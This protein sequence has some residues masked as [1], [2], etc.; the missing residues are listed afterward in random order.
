[1]LYLSHYVQSTEYK[2]KKNTIQY[3]STNVNSG[4]KKK[5]EI[6][7]NKQQKMTEKYE[8][9][10][11]KKEEN[12]NWRDEDLNGVHLEEKKIF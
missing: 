7:Y 8:V 12:W 6:K 2:T 4:K 5:L 9:D 3:K 10:R 1:M 11:K